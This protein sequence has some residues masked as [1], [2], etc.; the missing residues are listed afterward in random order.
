MDKLK[1]IKIENEDGSLSDNIPLGVDAE[2]VDLISENGSQNLAN[3]INKN[4]INI[5]SM[6]SQIDSLQDNDTSLSNQIKSLSSGSPKG[7]YANSEAL[8]AANPDTGVYIITEN[9]HIYSWTKDGDDPIDLGIYQASQPSDEL[10]IT[11]KYIT[12]FVKSIIYGAIKINVDDTNITVNITSPNIWLIANTPKHINTS[13][14]NYI[15]PIAN[16]NINSGGIWALYL[17][18]KGIIKLKN[19]VNNSNFLDKEDMIIMLFAQR[20]TQHISLISNNL[21]YN[22]K[23]VFLDNNVAPFISKFAKFLVYGIIDLSFDDNNF[24]VKLIKQTNFNIGNENT[25]YNLNNFLIENETTYSF[26]LQDYP[27]LTSGVWCIA[28]SIDNMT[29]SLNP[30][31]IFNMFSI[32]ETTIKNSLLNYNDLILGIISNRGNSFF[33]QLQN[34]IIYNNKSYGINDIVS[35]INN[36][37]NSLSYDFLRCFK[38]FTGIG[39]SLMAGYTEIND[40]TINSQSAKQ[41]K[42]NWLEYLCNRLNRSCNNL[43][44]GSSTTENWRYANQSGF[45]D[46]NIENANIPT[47]CY[48]LALGVNDLRKGKTIGNS[49]DINSDNLDNNANSFYGNYDYLVRKLKSFNTSAKIFLFTIPNS[50][51]NAESYNIAIRYISTLYDNVYLIDLYNLTDYSINFIENN[52]INGHYNPIT[53]NYMSVLIEKLINNFIYNNFLDFQLIPYA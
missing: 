19:I 7:T 9:G 3:Y 15:F 53:Y 14:L 35:S 33:T 32:D 42:N 4:N 38:N 12:Q 41:Q 26:S 52:F 45:P 43:A 11:N 31:K 49:T 25:L 16:Y 20:N 2:N 21:Y 44:M 36:N 27:I 6:N 39:D 29:N 24:Y 50:E 8:K 23:K 30:I 18:S 40:T 10:A 46:T 51:N 5:N 34:N 13:Q 37:I 48:F 1:Y 28:L 17:D 22:N 47:D